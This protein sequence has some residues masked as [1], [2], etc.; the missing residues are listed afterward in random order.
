[1]ASRSDSRPSVLEAGNKRGHG[2]FFLDNEE[3]GKE[4][5]FC[6]GE[7]KHPLLAG[8]VQTDKAE[9]FSNQKAQRKAS[10]NPQA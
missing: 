8:R 3:T 6:I 2:D 5:I 1:M 10:L 4:H 9:R 7:D